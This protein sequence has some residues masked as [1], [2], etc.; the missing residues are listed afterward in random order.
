MRSLG[1]AT[2]VV[3]LVLHTGFYARAATADDRKALD[4]LASDVDAALRTA[5]AGTV[6]LEAIRERLARFLAAPALP[7]RFQTPHPGLDVTTYLLHA[8]PDGSFSIAALVLRPGKGAPLHDHR[9]WTVWGTLRGRD[10]ER[11]FERRGEGETFPD[12]VPIVDHPVAAGAVSIVEAPPRDVHV[13]ENAGDTPSVSIHVHGADLSQ[14]TRNRYDLERR[15]VLPFVQTY[16]RE[17]GEP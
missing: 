15:S 5:P 12:L 9:T 4:A 14:I 13:V 1:A 10:R 6:P 2:V 7:E 16:V 17:G 8:A 3:A 11:Q